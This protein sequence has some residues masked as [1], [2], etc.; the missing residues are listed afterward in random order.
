MY[1]LLTTLLLAAEEEPS[2]TDL[3]LPDIKELIAGI[4]AFAIVFF[5]IW[6]FAGPALNQMLENRRQ[7]VKGDLEAAEAAKAEAQSLLDDYKQQLADARTEA[8]RIIDEARESADT[9]KADIISKAESDASDI[10]SKAQADL[11]GERERAQSALRSEV[12]GL[13]LDVAEKVVGSSLDRS[14]SQALVD[15]FIDE[16]GQ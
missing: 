15:Q 2:G 4:I 14:A 5:F 6:K 3:L 9:M 10:R 13:S 1:T 11:S 16:L 7:A 12:A 8:S